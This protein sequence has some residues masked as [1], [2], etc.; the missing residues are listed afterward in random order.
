MPR[1]KKIPEKILQKFCQNFEKNEFSNIYNKMNYMKML[2][3]LNP[4]NKVERPVKLIITENQFKSLISKINEQP[5][6][7]LKK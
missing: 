3:V 6:K 7:Q 2:K 1:T 4:R 5:S